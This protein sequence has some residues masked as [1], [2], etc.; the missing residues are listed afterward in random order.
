[1]TEDNP[2]HAVEVFIDELALMPLEFP[3]A[4][5]ATTAPPSYHP[6]VLLKLYLYRHLNRIQFSRRLERECQRSKSMEMTGNLLC[7]P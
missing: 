2:V 5:P 7:F 3:D 1:M 4:W 6:S